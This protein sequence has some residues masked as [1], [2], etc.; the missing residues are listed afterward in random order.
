[1]NGWLAAS[2]D[3]LVAEYS[4]ADAVHA[5]FAGSVAGLLLILALVTYSARTQRSNLTLLTSAF[6]R[7]ISEVRERTIRRFR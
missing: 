2:G 7:N 1:M 5:S 6:V 4:Y 3:P